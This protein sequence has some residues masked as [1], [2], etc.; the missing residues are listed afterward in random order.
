MEDKKWY[1]IRCS[2]GKEKKAKKHI[3]SEIEKQNLSELVS[4]L[5][6]P[7]RKEVYVKS[8]KKVSRDVNYY[9]GYVLIEAN[10]NVEIQHIIKETSGVLSI[11]GGKTKDG[12]DKPEPLRNDEIKK[13]LGKIDD[14]LD[15]SEGT[16]LN[17]VIGENVVISDGPFTNF[18]GTVEEINEDKKRVKVAIKIFGRK[19]PVE[20]EFSQIIKN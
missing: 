6:I 2:S 20:L 14:S 4:R 10:L 19:T 18:N 5:I 3:E 15:E 12:K 1:V 17:F 16:K 8:G 9:P 11:L 13:I 7:T